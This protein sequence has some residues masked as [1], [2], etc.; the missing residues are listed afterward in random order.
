[1]PRVHLIAIDSCISSDRIRRA[2]ALGIS[3]V[4]AFSRS[5]TRLQLPRLT[6][7]VRSAKRT[8]HLQ[9]KEPWSKSSRQQTRI[10]SSQGWAK[11]SKLD[12]QSSRSFT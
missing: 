10:K 4:M 11:L 9:P 7:N 3:R 6:A 5:I 2:T 1:M 12:F 8:N